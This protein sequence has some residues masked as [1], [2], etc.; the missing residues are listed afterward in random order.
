MAERSASVEN[1]AW[2]I[3]FRALSAFPATAVAMLREAK[4]GEGELKRQAPH[5]LC[6]RGDSLLTRAARLGNI[7]AARVLLDL[8]AE[9]D[10][11]TRATDLSPLQVACHCGHADLVT[12]LLERGASITRRN[13]RGLTAISTAV[14]TMDVRCLDILV[15]AGA[16]LRS[17]GL[18]RG[19]TLAQ[20]AASR[21]N[22]NALGYLASKGVNLFE[23]DLRGLTALNA[24]EKAS[25]GPG[26]TA[27]AGPNRTL[28]FLYDVLHIGGAAASREWTRYQRATVRLP[29]VGLRELVVA[30]RATP[31]PAERGS[32]STADA[33]FRRALVF[34]TSAYDD[35]DGAAP[36][37]ER[38]LDDVRDGPAAYRPTKRRYHPYQCTTGIFRHIVSF[39]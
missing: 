2:T 15:R 5:E 35:S 26:S 30:G 24:A 16:D 7:D 10:W 36:P 4:F 1:D 37:P 3:A 38:L 6:S 8:G 28:D 21:G 23:R 13:N 12:F 31:K 29:I 9:L 39:V 17:R 22:L 19:N 14:H 34:A 18:A 27:G 20:S 25:R 11:P 32:L 33:R